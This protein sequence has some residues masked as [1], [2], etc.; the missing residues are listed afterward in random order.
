MSMAYRREWREKE[1]KDEEG[2]EECE[3]AG[4]KKRE[5]SIEKNRHRQRERVGEKGKSSEAAK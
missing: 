3:R 4:R 1:G 2:A 5:K